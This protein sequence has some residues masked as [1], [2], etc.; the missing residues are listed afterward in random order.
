MNVHVRCVR[1]HVHVR[2]VRV[3]CVH[4]RGV[5]GRA[6]VAWTRRSDTMGQ[7]ARALEHELIPPRSSLDPSSI[8][9]PRHLTPTGHAARSFSA[10][11]RQMRSDRAEQAGTGA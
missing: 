4:V 6:R 10:T 9:D 3:R 11:R 1:V 2:C 5:R 7:S 8:L